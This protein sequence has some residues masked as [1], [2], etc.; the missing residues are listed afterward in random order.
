MKI[1]KTIIKDE[2]DNL[3][4]NS[5]KQFNLAL[6]FACVI[7][8]LYCYFGSFSFFE[9][10]FPNVQNLAFWKIIYHNLMS[11]VL[12]FGLGVVYTRFIIKNSPAEFG[13]KLENKKFAMWTILIAIP[14]CI[15][16]GLT[17]ILDAG[18]KSTYPLIDFNIYSQWYFILP[19]F[20]SYLLY[21]IGWEYLFRGLLLNS[22][23]PKCG[24]M[25]AILITTLISSL[26]HTSIAGFGKP[27]VETLSAIPA[28]LIFGYIAIKTKSIY[29]TLIIH[30]LIGFST[31]IFIFFLR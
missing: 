8:F 1:N 24:A 16:I 27:M 9:K 29:P 10:T 5:S 6:I 22:A 13:L 21:Y 25:G 31:D 30:T 11:F 14:I 2:F 20:I 28:G 7:L 12:F 23:E 4:K 26:I 17:T 19:Y 3:N 18:M 15:L